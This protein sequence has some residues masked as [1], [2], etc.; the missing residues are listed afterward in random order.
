MENIPTADQAREMVEASDFLP[1]T[2]SIKERIIAEINRAAR[3][4][5]TRAGIFFRRD[6][7]I[8]DMRE[9]AQILI[10]KG[11]RVQTDSYYG[12]L[13]S[14]EWNEEPERDRLNERNERTMRTLARVDHSNQLIEPFD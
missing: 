10:D 3:K 1:E 9:T 4:G 14:V 11:Y 2:N 13:L 6:E 8:V 5:E 12:N 7:D